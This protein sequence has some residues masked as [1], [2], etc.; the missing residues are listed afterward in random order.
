MTRE[1]FIVG[2]GYTGFR[3]AQ[4]EQ[5]RGAHVRA[6]VRSPGNT[7]RLRATGIEP[8]PGDLDDP[9]SLLALPVDEGIIYYFVPPPAYG[10]DDP[11]LRALL[12]AIGRHGRP[13]RLVLLSTTGVYGDCGGMWVDEERPPN[14]QTDRAR[15][16]L[17]A[18]QELQAWAHACGVPFAILRVAGI[19]GPGRLPIERLQRGS[20][21]LREAESPWSNRVHVD[22]LVTA[23]LAAADQDDSGRIYNISDGHPTTMTN[24]FNS[25]ADA[26]GLPRPPQVSMAE[27]QTALS[28]E[29]LSYLSESRRLDNSRMRNELGV[30]L[31]Y[32]TLAE[33]LP[34][35]TKR[36]AE[37]G[38]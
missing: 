9:A 34:A 35:C 25:V 20:P 21:V 15:R 17:A 38:Q 6:L 4:R 29:M 28:A 13:H 26:C 37:Q 3:V 1:V 14:P 24:Y 23:C 7:E 5:K 22:D 11:R 10:V 8:V 32:P 18:E 2:C 30:V 33:G 19:Y 36:V 27:A 31:R 12:D 16:R